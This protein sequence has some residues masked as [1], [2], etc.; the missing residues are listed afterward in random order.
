[1]EIIDIEKKKGDKNIMEN[2][3]VREHFVE[4]MAS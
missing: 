2:P 4:E 1:M 3:E